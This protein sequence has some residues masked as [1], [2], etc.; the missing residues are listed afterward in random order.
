MISWQTAHLSL[1]YRNGSGPC[2]QEYRQNN[3]N[4]KTFIYEILYVSYFDIISCNMPEIKLIADIDHPLIYTS[5]DF[6]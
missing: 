4:M 6:E 5:F 1:P 3:N 2:E